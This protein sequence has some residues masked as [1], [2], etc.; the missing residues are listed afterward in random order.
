MK[1][2][3]FCIALCIAPFLAW[4]QD[5]T[6]NFWISNGK[7]NVDYPNPAAM[8]AS[9]VDNSS[10]LFGN[11]GI[12]ALNAGDV[13][14]RG[15]WGVV[16]DKNGGNLGENGNYMNGVNPAGGSFAV[17]TRTSTTAFRTD[18]IIRNN[19]NIGIGTNVPDAK[20]TV[21]GQIHAQE[22]LIDLANA[23][24]PDYVFDK[25]YKLPSLETIKAYV[26]QH[27][28]LP[29]VPS[30]KEME[31]KGIN[32]REMNLLLLK[33]IEELTLY[34]ITQEELNTRQ[35]KLIDELAAKIKNLETR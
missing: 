17:R 19:G 30:A 28:H 9:Q 26:D 25:T 15:F 35:Q 6:G 27:H 11:Q 2:I 3:L 33:K 13:H 18:F 24:A 20:L 32:V 10:G 14:I 8:T 21:K 4:S 34:A 23:V 31:E 1:Q 12:G 7:L 5:H 29:E 22:V 16:I